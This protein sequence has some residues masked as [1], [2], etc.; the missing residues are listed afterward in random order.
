MGGRHDDYS[1]L[2]PNVYWV[3]RNSGTALALVPMGR[4]QDALQMQPGRDE[5]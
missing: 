3:L 2:G 5:S 4:P 1:G